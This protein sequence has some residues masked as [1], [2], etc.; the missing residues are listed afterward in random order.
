MFE[1]NLTRLTI[2]SLGPGASAS[3]GYGGLH[4]TTIARALPDGAKFN[5]GD[6]RLPRFVKCKNFDPSSAAIPVMAREGPAQPQ[7]RGKEH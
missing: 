3:F 7:N 1:R 6:K 4:L 2:A 5:S